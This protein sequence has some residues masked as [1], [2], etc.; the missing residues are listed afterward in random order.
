MLHLLLLLLAMLLML[1]A[2][3]LLHVELLLLTL[4]PEH[5]PLPEKRSTPQSF[6]QFSCCEACCC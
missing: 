4:Q 3:L 6:V 1:P 5:L 2:L